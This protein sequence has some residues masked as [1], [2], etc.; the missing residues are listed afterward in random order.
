MIIQY[1]IIGIGGS[2]GA[3][4]RFIIETWVNSCS[5]SSVFPFGTL[6]VNLIGCLLIGFLFGIIAI[7]QLINPRA[8][9]FLTVGFLGSL[10][11]FSSFGY[12]TFKLIGDREFLTALLNV[13]IQITAGLTAVWAG[14]AIS[15]ILAKIST[16]NS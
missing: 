14:F 15:K 3:I 5:G 10:T 8:R 4:L 2:C 1:I 7:S 12:E 9:L 13:L 16:S 6:T 11:T